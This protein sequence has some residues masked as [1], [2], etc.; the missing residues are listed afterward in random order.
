M[1]DAPALMQM[2]QAIRQLLPDVAHDVPATVARQIVPSAGL[3]P[4]GLGATYG[5]Q[6]Q[7]CARPLALAQAEPPFASR[8]YAWCLS[9]IT[10]NH[11]QNKNENMAKNKAAIMR[12]SVATHQSL[13]FPTVKRSRSIAVA[14]SR[15]ARSITQ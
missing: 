2:M 3:G 15:S 11:F 4:M 8:T 13:S 12:A 9:T 1:D 14:R 6:P 10:I 5:F 7:S